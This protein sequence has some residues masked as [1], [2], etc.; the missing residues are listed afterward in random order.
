[1][2]I[3]FAILYMKLCFF[4]LTYFLLL[5]SGGKDALVLCR[6]FQKS[7]PGPKNGEK[8]G[9]PFVEEEWEEDELEIVPKEEAAEEVEFGDDIFLD[10]HDLEQVYPLMMYILLCSIGVMPC[11]LKTWFIFALLCPPQNHT[12][13]HTK[14]T[15]TCNI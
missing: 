13:T 10:G 3:V 9:A 1:M 2:L 5:F 12:R 7:G 8:Y 15:K 4:K 11:H 14:P 6:V